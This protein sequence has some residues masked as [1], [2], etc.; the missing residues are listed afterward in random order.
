MRKLDYFISS[1]SA[2]LYQNISQKW[3]RRQDVSNGDD[4]TF[5]TISAR[6]FLKTVFYRFGYD[7]LNAKNRVVLSLTQIEQFEFRHLTKMVEAP[8]NDFNKN[9]YLSNGLS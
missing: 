3:W 8:G 9:G 1:T 4:D 6:L 7:E 2:K 5:L